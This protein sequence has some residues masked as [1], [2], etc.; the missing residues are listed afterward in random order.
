MLSE[1]SIVYIEIERQI[2]F[3]FQQKQIELQYELH[4]SMEG[5]KSA[6]HQFELQHVHDVSHKSF[7]FGGGILY[8]HTNQGVFSYKIQEDPNPFIQTFKS[9]KVRSL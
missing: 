4:L 2:D 9:L 7:S 8:L 3:Y 5:I 6:R 1:H